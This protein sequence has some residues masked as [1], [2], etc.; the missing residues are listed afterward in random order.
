L[1]E[2][3]SSLIS[4]TG[5]SVFAV[6][7]LSPDAGLPPC[8]ADTY[9][10]S[11]PHLAFAS[12]SSTTTSPTLRGRPEIDDD[13]DDDGESRRRR[14]AKRQKIEPSEEGVTRAM[15]DTGLEDSDDPEQA[16]I[17]R[18]IRE[19]LLTSKDEKDGSAAA[20]GSKDK[21]KG[22]QV[23]EDEDDDF[24]RALALSMKNDNNPP[25]G[26]G[27]ESDRD[28]EAEEEQEVNGTSDAEEEAPSVEELRRR[29]LARFG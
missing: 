24:Q 13:D 12:Y 6:K 10:L 26:N 18:A 2:R 29:R 17:D 1:Q 14:P 16:M 7:G 19:S 27:A 11:N 4:P 8:G 20:G 3:R 28:E 21:G 23:D 25:A 5:Y 22:K 9:F 15:R